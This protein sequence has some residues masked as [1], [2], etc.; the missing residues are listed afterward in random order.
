[1]TKTIQTPIIL[2]ETLAEIQLRYSET[3]TRQLAVNQCLKKEELDKLL[4]SILTPGPIIKIGVLQWWHLT[5]MLKQSA[6]T[7]PDPDIATKLNTFYNEAEAYLV[8]V[9]CAFRSDIERQI[10]H[11]RLTTY[12]RPQFG[13]KN[14]IAMD[15]YPRQVK[16]YIKPDTIS[17]VEIT[18]SLA[19]RE[20]D[21]SSS[22]WMNIVFKNQTPTIIGDTTAESAP[23]WEYKAYQ[24]QP[25]LDSRFGYLII[26]KPRPAKSV[27]LTLDI[28]ASV[29]TPLGLL[30]AEV[31]EKDKPILTSK[32]CNEWI[33]LL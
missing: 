2:E 20:K 11:A 1:M 29:H 32:I 27:R 8:Q 31:K 9:S 19:F 22:A 12:L 18:S 3:S 33:D 5:P 15:I 7:N 30:V 21:E 17:N 26:K 16:S 4:S 25:L 6:R 14:P 28:N 13:Q 23:Y 24:G 10:E